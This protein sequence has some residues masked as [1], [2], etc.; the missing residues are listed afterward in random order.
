MLAKEELLSMMVRYGSTVESPAE[1]Q[2]AALTP[3]ASAERRQVDAW[4]ESAR[5]E[6]TRRGQRPDPPPGATAVSP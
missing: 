3:P 6:M 5:A 4:L 1:T 2:T